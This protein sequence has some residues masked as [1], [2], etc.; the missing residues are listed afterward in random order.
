MYFS[1]MYAQADVKH[2]INFI[3]PNDKLNIDQTL[4]NDTYWQK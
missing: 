1:E 2:E 3:W 4:N